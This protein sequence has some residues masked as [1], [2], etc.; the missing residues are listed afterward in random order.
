M[1]KFEMYFL[2]IFA[3]LI[4][5]NFWLSYILNLKIREIDRLK[6]INHRLKG[7]NE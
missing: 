5:F 6:V 2:M 3:L 4:T 1:T 7:K